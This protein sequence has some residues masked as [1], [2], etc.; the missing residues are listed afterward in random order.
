MKKELKNKATHKKISIWVSNK[1][2]EILLYHEDTLEV[3]TDHSKF[4]C[5]KH[6][7]SCFSVG[8][9]FAGYL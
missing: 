3:E 2:Q 7:L 5:G 1:S 9:Q 8:W 6:M 4:K